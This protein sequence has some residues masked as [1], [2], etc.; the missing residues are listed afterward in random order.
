[1]EAQVGNIKEKMEKMDEKV[2]RKVDSIENRVGRMETKLEGMD[3]RLSKDLKAL[4]DKLVP[5]HE[6]T[7]RGVGLAKAAAGQWQRTASN[8]ALEPQ[9]Q[10]EPEP[11]PEPG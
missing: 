5:A 1:M 7:V 10:L 9:R 8:R 3:E 11:E 2:D 4:V 6:P